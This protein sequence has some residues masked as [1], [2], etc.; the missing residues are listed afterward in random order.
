MLLIAG[1]G[2]PGGSYAGHRHNI[3]FMCVDAIASA[4][5]FGPWRNRFQ[6]EVCEGALPTA[7]GSVKTLLLK[8]M[9]F[10]NDS[11]RSVGQAALF[12]K[13]TL[14]QTVVIY[15][16]L[17]LEPGKVRVKTGGGAAGHNGIKS[18]AAHVG[19]EFR[20]VRLGIGHPGDKALVQAHVL[21]NFSKAERTA[22]VDRLI[23]AVAQAAPLL[24]VP[25]DVGFM[26]KVALLAQAP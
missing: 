11:G 21:S 19:I 1:L 2:N 18:V 3:G 13:V 22:W 15:D 16:E 12:Y 6:G 5:N 8:P 17:D 14:R 23:D 4:H 9:T 24:A 25:D 20:R 26:N 10:M 7:A